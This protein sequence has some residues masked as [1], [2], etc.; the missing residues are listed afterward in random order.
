MVKNE[1]KGGQAEVVWTCHEERPGVCRKKGDGNGITRKEEKKEAEEKISG[2]S[3]GGYGG[4]WCE[5]E[6]HW[7][8]DI[9]EEHHMPWLHLIKGKGLKKNHTF[10]CYN[11]TMPSGICCS[12]AGSDNCSY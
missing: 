5:G 11:K 12:P 9:V 6:G 3:E 4:S 8:E 10:C 2:C 1:G 7:K